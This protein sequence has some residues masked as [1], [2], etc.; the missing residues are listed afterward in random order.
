VD[1]QKLDKGAEII[2]RIFSHAGARSDSV[3]A[4]LPLGAHPSA[5]CRIGEVV[6]VHLETRIQNLFCCDA[7]VFPSSL[8]LPTMWTVV[9]LAKRLATHLNKR[10]DY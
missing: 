1:K 7:S 6:D 4:T 8:G 5:T 9:S 2:Q 10:L 3:F